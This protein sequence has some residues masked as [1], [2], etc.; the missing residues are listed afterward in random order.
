MARHTFSKQ[1]QS[2]L[3]S[4]GTKTLAQLDDSFGAK[5]FGVALLLLMSVPAL[6][7]PTGGITHLFELIAL[8]LSL[9]LIAGRTTLWLPKRWRKMRLGDMLQKK[10]LPKLLGATRWIERFSRPR[11]TKLFTNTLGLR[12]IGA[13]VFLLTLAAA[14]AP[15]FFGL[16]TLPALGVVMVALSLLLEDAAMFGI[17]CLTGIAGIV[18]EISLGSL[19]LHLLS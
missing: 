10:A 6:P 3:E 12:I 14:L 18:L 16:D 15:P 13:V 7:L 9:E 17:G 11:F 5:S 4:K 2:W 1:L 19:A 8:L